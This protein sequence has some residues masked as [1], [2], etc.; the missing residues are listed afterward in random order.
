M[1][2]FLKAVWPRCPDLVTLGGGTSD[3]VA[4]LQEMVGRAIT[5]QMIDERIPLL[6]ELISGPFDAD[7]LDYYARD[8]HMSGTPS[9]LDISRLIQKITIREVAQA[10][11]PAEIARRVERSDKPHWIFGIRW[12]GIAVLDELHLARVLLYSKIYRHPKVVAIEQMLR[13]F[14][15]ILVP[16]SSTKALIE[17]FYN[18]EDDVILHLKPRDLACLVNSDKKGNAETLVRLNQAADILGRIKTRRL[19]VK[20]FQ[21]HERYPADELEHDDLQKRGSTSSRKTLLIRNAASH[22]SK[23]F[24]GKLRRY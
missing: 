6:H 11:L 3:N 16:I 15:S 4:K 7:K 1:H 14:V 2:D 13:A 17:F 20:S 22:L 23:K 12:S 19:V 21:L 9:L 10:D 5:G 18:F 24:E 8:A